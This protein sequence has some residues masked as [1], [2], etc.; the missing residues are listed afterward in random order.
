MVQDEIYRIEI[1]FHEIGGAAYFSLDWEYSGRTRIAVP[2]PNLA[3][4]PSVFFGT[5]PI[6]LD[7]RCA[8][9]SAL[10]IK[11]A[12]GTNM[13]GQYWILINGTPTLVY[14]VMNSSQGGGGWMLAMR[15][16]NHDSIFKYNSAYW[17]NTALTDNSSYP[18][19]FSASDT[20]DTYRNT[21]AKYAPFAS[22]VGNQVL[23]LYPEV[24]NK[25]GGAYASGNLSGVP[26]A[27]PQV[28]TSLLDGVV[29]QAAMIQLIIQQMLERLV[30]LR[31]L[32][33]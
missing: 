12:T 28:E 16:K 5:C 8:A 1:W 30:R 9:G 32:I 2:L 11:R 14:C 6:G 25:A 26:I 10:E 4:D 18:E 31:H 15:G 24:T 13:D 19:R 20:I 29:T 27:P 22:T 17:T 7:P 21:D 3:T 23:V 33:V